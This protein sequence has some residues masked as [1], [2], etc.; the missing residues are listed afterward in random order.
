MITLVNRQGIKALCYLISYL[1]EQF[2]AFKH[3][4]WPIFR[5]VFC[6]FFKKIVWQRWLESFAGYFSFIENARISIT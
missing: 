5:Y 1:L 6:Q 3:F 2:Y 4:Q